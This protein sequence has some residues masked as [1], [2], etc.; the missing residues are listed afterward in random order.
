MA[1]N[2]TPSTWLGSGYAYGTNQITLN[3]E[4]HGT[5]LLEEL[6]AA[7]LEE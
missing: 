7:K 2:Q 5:P 3:T 1:F 4:A 6:T